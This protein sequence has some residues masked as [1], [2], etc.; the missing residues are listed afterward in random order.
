[1]YRTI[2]VP[3]IPIPIVPEA[4]DTSAAAPVPA[5]PVPAQP[6]PQPAAVVAVKPTPS[7]EAAGKKKQPKEP[8][9][10]DQT[11]GAP[12]AEKKKAQAPRPAQGTLI[13]SLAWFPKAYSKY[14]SFY[15]CKT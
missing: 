9:L 2:I 14:Y 11:E 7:A 6:V 5:A 13:P 15:F 8:K 3:Q 4:M 1:M 12:P 10:K